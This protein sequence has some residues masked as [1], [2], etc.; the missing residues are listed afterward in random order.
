MFSTA[1][2]GQDFATEAKELFAKS[3]RSNAPGNDDWIE[4]REEEEEEEVEDPS[5][6]AEGSAQ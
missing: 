1:D 2:P 4:G 3:K 6:Q 5:Q